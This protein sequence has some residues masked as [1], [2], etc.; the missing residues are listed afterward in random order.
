MKSVPTWSPF[1]FM[2]SSALGKVASVVGWPICMDGVVAKQF[3]IDF[4]QCCVEILPKEVWVKV[5][6]FCW[7]RSG[8]A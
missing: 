4:A 3:R 2:G 8:R 5:H 6:K 7:V 1:L